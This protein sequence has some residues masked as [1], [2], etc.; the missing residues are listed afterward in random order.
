MRARVGWTSSAAI[1]GTGVGGI[2]APIGLR[3]GP[4]GLLWL[5]PLICGAG[6]LLVTGS[7]AFRGRPTGQHRNGQYRFRHSGSGQ[8]REGRYRDRQLREGPYRFRQSG[9]GQ[10][11]EARYRFRQAREGRYRFRQLRESRYRFPQLR[12]GGNRLVPSRFGP[13]GAGQP[14]FGRQ[15]LSL[16]HRG[17]YQ[18][19]YQETNAGQLRHG[20][21]RR[22]SSAA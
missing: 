13:P 14:G 19:P 10:L 22:I 21:H 6:L 7:P 17:R 15:W 16:S 8:L 2:A 9:S 4:L 3:S 20:R 12:E 1:L 11:R 5:I 18:H